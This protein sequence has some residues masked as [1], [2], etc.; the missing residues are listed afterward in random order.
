MKIY[1]IVELLS[2]GSANGTKKIMS[3][4]LS[5]VRPAV[6]FVFACILVGQAVCCWQ[7]LVGPFSF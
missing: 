3:L 7:R 4:Q 6:I 1:V 2:V 5:V